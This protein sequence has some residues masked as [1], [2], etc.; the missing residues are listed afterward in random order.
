[1]FLFLEGEALLSLRK[2]SQFKQKSKVTSCDWAFDGSFQVRS[3][4]WRSQGE[5]NKQRAGQQK[6]LLANP[7]ENLQSWA[8]PVK[9]NPG[10]GQCSKTLDAAL[11]TWTTWRVLDWVGVWWFSQPLPGPDGMDQNWEG[12]LLLC[13]APT[14]PEI[15]AGSSSGACFWEPAKVAAGWLHRVPGPGRCN[16]ERAA[17]A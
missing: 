12:F 11:C 9:L 10:A 15:F 13:S 17:W 1:M 7:L 2:G 16:S 8:L 4:D 6:R 14:N 5:N 3:T